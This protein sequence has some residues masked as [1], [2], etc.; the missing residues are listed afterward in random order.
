[1]VHK[2]QHILTT[3]SLN[4]TQPMTSAEV[5]INTPADIDFKFGRISFAKAASIIRMF[6]FAM[7]EDNFNTAITN[8]LKEL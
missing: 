7:G 5:D 6:R 1:M 8:Y 3:D 2:L 4:L